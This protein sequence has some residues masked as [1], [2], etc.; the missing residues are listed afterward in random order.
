M[1]TVIVTTHPIQY[2]AP[3]FR[4]L[5]EKIDLTVVFLMQQTRQGQAASG[6]G[7][8]FEWD[9][10]LL[11]GYRH[12]FANNIALSPS[13]LRRDGVVLEGH[14]SLL[15]S[16]K[17]DVMLV[18]GWFPHGRMQVIK[19]AERAKV[20]LVCRGESNL[21][22]GRSLPKRLAKLI[23]FRWLL[24]K[25]LAFTVIGKSNHDFYRHYGVLESRLHWSPY[26]ID[27]DFFEREFKR[28]RTASR[29]PGTWRVGFSGKL[30]P[31]KRPLDLVQALAGC[32]NKRAVELI[33]IGDGLL[34]PELETKAREM[35]VKLDVR[36]FLNQGEIVSK[37]YADLDVLVLPSDHETWGL[38]VNE[39]MTGGIPAIVSDLTGC[40][41]DLV[42][43]DETGHVYPAGNV[44]ALSKA[45]ERLVER[46]Q[47]GHDFGPA[48]CERIGC[49]SMR[50]TLEGIT[51][52]LSA[53]AGASH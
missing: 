9:T 16:L 38:V 50:K 34:R 49:Y 45:I 15:A 25:F 43:E 7:V 47:N 42:S 36:G 53:A 41:P 4:G 44:K 10:P 40:A 14:E 5:A 19:W 48:V 33:I 32:K 11:E 24:R 31:R 46:L 26:S 17:P 2:Q 23:Y 27:T 13:T 35:G 39:A 52:A 6:F 28:H 30:I 12:V 8:E 21:I 1:R 3:L 37:G 18:T 51:K 29:K 22:S 20:P